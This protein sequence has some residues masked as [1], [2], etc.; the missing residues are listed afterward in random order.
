MT[1]ETKWIFTLTIGRNDAKV[2]SRFVRNRDYTHPAICEQVVDHTV[3]ITQDAVC[4]NSTTVI[5][6][7]S[8]YSPDQRVQDL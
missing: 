8:A 3:W 2:K 7:R 4:A 1:T 6:W 5:T